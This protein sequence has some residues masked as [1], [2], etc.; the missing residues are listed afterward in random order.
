MFTFAIVLMLFA[1]VD[2]F[3]MNLEKL[4]TPEE[5]IDMG[6]RLDNSFSTET[7]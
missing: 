3:L 5:L 6:I 1:I 4:F 2:S 7:R